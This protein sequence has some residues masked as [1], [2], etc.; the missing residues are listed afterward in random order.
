MEIKTPDVKPNSSTSSAET[1]SETQVKTDDVKI[2]ATFDSVADGLIEAALS[3]ESDTSA[4]DKDKEEAA[5]GE[6]L[7]KNGTEEAAEEVEKE[8]TSTEEDDKSTDDDDKKDDE[9]TD[10]ES[11]DEEADDDDK[12]DEKTSTETKDKAKT[13]GHE[14][15]VPY[16]R[17]KEVNDKATTY[18]PLAK[19]QQSVVDYCQKNRIS[20]EQYQDALATMAM[21]NTDPKAGLAKLK[22][23]VSQFEIGL[24]ESLPT[25]LQSEL[26]EAKAEVEAGTLSQARYATM[27]KRA[28]ELAKTR[29][30]GQSAAH[31]Q[32]QLAQET[33][34]KQ[35]NE[36]LSA[37]AVWSANKQKTNPGFKPKAKDSDPDGMFEDFLAKNIYYWQQTPGST[38]A[39]AI[40]LADKAFDATVGLAKRYGEKPK[41]RKVISSVN[42]SSRKQLNGEPK[43]MDDVAVA[44]GRKHGYSM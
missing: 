25:D 36:M 9:Q 23:L 10:E 18:E 19:A 43:S 39:E 24:G 41:A 35:Q 6:V 15:A 32:Q 27:E 17:F 44:V 29:V 7:K 5:S 37:L 22:E 8:E 4:E 30:Q 2:K 12:G 20:S 42:A 33:V 34:Q 1:Q 21:L 11:E 3:Q 38:I 28:K 31:R 26:T 14:K 40:Q 16:Q 13:N